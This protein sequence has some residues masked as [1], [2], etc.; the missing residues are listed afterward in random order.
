MWLGHAAPHHGVVEAEL[1]Q[2]LGHLGHVAEHVGQVADRHGAAEGGGAVEAELEVADHGLARHQELVHQDV[3]GAHGQPTR[4]GQAAQHRL[5]LGAH[6]QVVV[7]HRHLAVEQEVGVGRVGVEAGEQVVEQ[8]DQA[9]AE[10]LV[11]L[12]PLAVPVGV[13]DDVH[14]SAVRRRR[15][16]PTVPGSSSRA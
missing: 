12:V 10:G 7:D 14:G 8:V 4:R 3:P 2:Q 11:R 15:A 1:A 16:G 6:G 9:Q 5:G 13:G